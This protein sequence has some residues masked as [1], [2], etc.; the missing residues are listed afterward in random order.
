MNT[1]Y[2]VNTMA[3]IS[4]AI[5]AL[6]TLLGLLIRF[7]LKSQEYDSLFL[8]VSYLYQFFT[9]L[10]NSLI[11]WV[12]GAISLRRPVHH[13]VVHAAVVSIIGV[14]II[15]HALLSQN[16]AKQGFDG[17]ANQITHSVVPVIS[18]IWWLVYA[19][20]QSL[21]WRDSFY[22]LIWPSAYCVYAL[23]RAEF[24]GFYPYPFI[25]LEQL[26]WG[27]LL[28]SIGYLSLAFLL[29]SLLTIGIAKIICLFK[30]KSVASM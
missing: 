30:N 9:I 5:I 22:A 26:G 18:L 4:A 17:L 1:H 6:I 27:G 21:K 10:T 2:Q 24:S 25:N 13:V 20:M 14:G 29:L 12:M 19:D 16:G 23:V 15:F 3:Q 11:L 28:K 8:G 7:V